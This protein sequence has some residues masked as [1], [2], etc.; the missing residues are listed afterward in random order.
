MP[1]L[2]SLAHPPFSLGPPH[3]QARV[4][5]VGE[6][7]LAIVLLSGGGEEAELVEVDTLRCGAR[8][9]HRGLSLGVGRE[10]EASLVAKRGAVGRC[11]AVVVAGSG[12]GLRG[13][14]RQRRQRR[15]R[16][17]GQSFGQ[18]AASGEGDTLL[19]VG[20][21]L[22]LP[23]RDRPWLLRHEAARRVERGGLAAHLHAHGQ[24]RG[25]AMQCVCSACAR[26]RVKM[27]GG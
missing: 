15:Q 13:G 3:Q 5:F 2:L 20:G 23:D 26:G 9:Q 17:L 11:V 12:G 1:Q 8:E 14:K 16:L 18:C 22:T 10:R 25:A 24:A 21:V 27:D 6:G 7:R 19:S 4:P